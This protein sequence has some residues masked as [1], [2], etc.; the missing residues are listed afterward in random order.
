MKEELLSLAGAAVEAAK[1]AGAGDAWAGASRSRQVEFS[2]RDGALEK[3]SE[4]TSQGLSLQVWVEGRYSSHHTTDLR[5]EELARF[6][7]DAV[8]LTRYLQADPFRAI[9]DPALFEGRPSLD[10]DLVDARVAALDR[11]GREALCH[12]QNAAL[13]G[14]ERVISAT[15]GSSDGTT[16]SASV[17]SNGFSGTHEETWLWIGSEVTLDDGAARP[18]GWFWAGG[19]HQAQVPAAQAVA[20]EALKRARD[21]LGSSKGPTLKGTLVVDPSAAGRLLGSL[22]A[23]ATGSAV[24]QGRS[25]WSGKLGQRVLSDKLSVVDDPLVPRGHGSRLYDGEGI[26]ARRRKLV[27]GGALA[28]M[29]VDTYYGRKLGVEPTTGGPS[30]RVVAPGS[31]DLA[32]ILA[33]LDDGIYVTSWLGGNS[34]S[35]TGDFSFGMRGHRVQRGVI[36]PPVGEMNVTGNLLDL[37]TRLVEV[38]SDP[39]PYSALVVP[40]LVFEGVDFSGA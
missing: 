30:N 10:L 3:V 29:Y 21:R 14:Q 7:R 19:K 4:A 18:E 2:V 13:A 34:D 27:E 15:S 40:T 5:P 11:A 17:S 24:Q 31:R 36:G 39:W 32:A 35:T 28:A 37:F 9:P 6:A 26:A 20:Q 33:D 12:E 22:L 8:A 38:G 1:A 25:F 23:P 16:V